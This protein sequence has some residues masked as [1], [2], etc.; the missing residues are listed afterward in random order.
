MFILGTPHFEDATLH[1]ALTEF[2]QCVLEG[3]AHCPLETREKLLL[4][5]YM[6]DIQQQLE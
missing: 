3:N 4:V 2:F 6:V 1:K 5:H